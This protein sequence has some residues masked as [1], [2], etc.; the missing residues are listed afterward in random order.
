MEL[1]GANRLLEADRDEKPVEHDGENYLQGR[2]VFCQPRF[3]SPKTLDR[4][5]ARRNSHHPGCFPRRRRPSPD[6]GAFGSNE[7]GR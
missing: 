7:T 4:R 6:S 5:I 3:T 2:C 1:T